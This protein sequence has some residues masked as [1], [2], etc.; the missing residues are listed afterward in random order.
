MSSEIKNRVSESSIKTID[1]EKFYPK[2]NREFID[3]SLWLD[4]GLVLREKEFRKKIESHKWISFKDKYVAIGC[5]TNAILPSWASLL[6]ASNLE[7]YA[8]KIIHGSLKELE[9]IIIEEVI[10]TLDIKPYIDKPVIIKGCSD[11]FIP[12]N[13]Y[14]Q[15]IILLKTVSRSLFYGE[16]CSSVPIW[17]RPK[18]N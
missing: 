5:S 2:G 6:V 15:L 1:L 3:I 16:A 7:P 17:K 11:N 8:K 12:E 18:T 10:K 9:N 13:A 4:N 14:V